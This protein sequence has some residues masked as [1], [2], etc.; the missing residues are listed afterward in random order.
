[1]SNQE[2]KPGALKKMFGH[3]FIAGSWSAFAAVIVIVIAVVANLIVNSL[4]AS[5]TQIDMTGNSLYSLSDQTKRIAAS[6]N[7]DVTLYLL[8]VSG[9]E[10]AT[11]TR[12]LSHY[13]DLSSHIRVEYVDPNQRP[14]FLKNYDL[15]TARL[16]QNSVIVESG[17]RYRLVGYDEI[18]VT[19]YNMDYYTYSYETT[20][21]FAGENAIT[22]AIHYVT[23]DNLPKVYVLSGHGEEELSETIT[24]MINQD[25]MTYESLSLLTLDAVPEDAAAVLINAPADDLGDDETDAL[26]AYLQNGGNVVLTTDYIEAGKME[27]LL[28]LTASMGLTVENGV[29]IEADRNMRISRYPHYLLP[30]VASHKITDALNEAGYY[31]LAP[32]AQPIV[33]TE[34]STASV[35]WLLT[36]SSSSYAKL[37]ALDMKTT[38]KEDGD[39]DGPF[40]VG[41]IS[42]K[43]GKLLWI[44]SAGLLNSSVDRTVAGGNS[45]LLLNALNWMGG[46]E[47][48]I[49]I[50]AKS[51]DEEGLTV[52]EASAGFWSVVMIGVIPAVLVAVGMIIY[53][54][55]KRQ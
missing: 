29:V 10:D 26:I 11:I 54:R 32:I 4:P 21:T 33:E 44:T 28:K 43:N 49:S 17:G 34:G 35:T 52:P 30:D 42:E 27:N 47:E 14:T 38:E 48:S 53:V 40:H 2:K 22:N 41:A 13:A 55:R 9:N 19:D 36:T 15:E 51:M 18:F 37:A 50:R 39:T 23:S 3:R 24:D 20:T 6:L 1:M 31:I 12:F 25:N 7:K 45:N 16:Y 46:Q 5:T 8:A